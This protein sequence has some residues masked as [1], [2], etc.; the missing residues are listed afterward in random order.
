M[1]E[2]SR[3]GNEVRLND[4]M[5]GS[6]WRIASIM[7]VLWIISNFYRI[8]NLQRIIAFL[9]R[10]YRKEIF[11]IHSSLAQFVSP[12]DSIIFFPFFNSIRLI[13]HSTFASPGANRSTHLDLISR[14]SGTFRFHKYK[15]VSWEMGEMGEI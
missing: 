1:A 15:S 2:S 14:S 4:R 5:D 9:L 12:I 10:V 8:L 3:R 7:D 6:T 13:F 11:F